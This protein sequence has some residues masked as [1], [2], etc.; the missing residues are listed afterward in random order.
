MIEQV[1]GGV[2][3]IETF[4]GSGSGMIFDTTSEDGALVLTNYH[5]VEDAGRIDVEVDDSTNY[6]GYIQWFDADIDLA[7]VRICCGDFQTLTFGDVSQIKPGSEVIVIGYPL[8]LPG[9][10]TV[11]RGIVSAIR[12]VGEFEV[13]QM[14]A[15][16]NP[17]NSGGPLLSPSG[18]VLGIN[19]FSIGDTEGLGFALSERLVQAILPEFQE[20]R[21]F[22]VAATPEP[23]PKFMPTFRPTPTSKPGQSIATPRPLPTAAPRPTS[24]PRP[25]ATLMPTLTPTPTPPPTP[26]PTPYPPLTL[27]PVPISANA[28]IHT[29]CMLRLDGTPVCW[30][31]QPYGQM[32]PPEGEKFVAISTGDTHICA[33]RADGTPMCWGWG[34]EN[35]S[36]QET[37]PE[38]EKFVAISVGDRDTCA[39]RANGTIACWGPASGSND[40]IRPPS[41]NASSDPLTDITL[42]IRTAC[43][44]KRSGEPACWGDSSDDHKWKGKR[45]YIWDERLRTISLGIDYLCG[46]RLDGTAA[47]F[48]RGYGPEYIPFA[49]G[50]EKFV[51]ISVG[52]RAISCGLRTK[53]TVTCWNWEKRLWDTADEKGITD[54]SLLPAS[55]FVQPPPEDERFIS[56]SVGEGFVCALRPDHT[57][58]CWGSNYYGQATPPTD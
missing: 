54:W 18:E 48:R 16:I 23:G 25:T 9:T 55:T 52:S 57:P 22:A 50:G 26:T 39:L 30:G 12:P 3:R 21:S 37:L 36:Y 14:D 43:W 6:R 8:G 35:Q 51:S 34:T 19:T 49:P 53:G 27:K 56:L 10:A 47:C 7:V 4:N 32:T 45:G 40:V 44:L 20:E 17:G 5:V 41:Y 11:T 15:P 13:I 24:R 42:T 46:L 2:V 58:V 1:K 29:T 31:W 33:L 38:R 28:A